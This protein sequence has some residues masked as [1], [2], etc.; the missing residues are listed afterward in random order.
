MGF[1]MVKHDRFHRFPVRLDPPV[2]L[3]RVVL[4]RFFSFSAAGGEARAAAR[5]CSGEENDGAAQTPRKKQGKHTHK[6]THT[7]THTH[8]YDG[9]GVC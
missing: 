6:H 9:R 4:K 7:H 8:K 1:P 5:C 3:E 2:A